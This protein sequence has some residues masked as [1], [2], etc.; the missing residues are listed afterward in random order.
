VKKKKAT[1][2]VSKRATT[3]AGRAESTAE[4]FLATCKH[5]LLEEIL[6]LRV[7]IRRAAPN[8]E[9]G[10]KW[11]APSYRMAGEDRITFNLSAKDRVR[12]IFHLGA[13]PKTRPKGRVIEFEADWL[14][15]PAEDRAI[16]TFASMAEIRRAKPEL[17]R[18]VQGWLAAAA[19][20]QD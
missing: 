19:H 12:L 8:L 3:I 9:E 4:A 13:K 2:K 10:I 14:E 15:W 11:N 18:L 5:A 7:Q 20:P 1:Q 16:A 6:A 17:K